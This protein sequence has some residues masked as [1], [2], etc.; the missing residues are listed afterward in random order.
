MQDCTGLSG[1]VKAGV[2]KHRGLREAPAPGSTAA[3]GRVR[4]RSLD[5]DPSWRSRRGYITS[6]VSITSIEAPPASTGHDR[7]RATAASRLSALRIV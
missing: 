6:T 5:P 4:T 2:G 3:T 7:E 1:P